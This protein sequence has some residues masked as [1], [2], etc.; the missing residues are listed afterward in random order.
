MI[1][2][3]I[4]NHGSAHP[5]GGKGIDKYGL[6]KFLQL[7]LS[8]L[9]MT[10]SV[11]PPAAR[12]LEGPV[13]RSEDSARFGE[14]AVLPSCMTLSVYRGD[15]TAGPSLLLIK[16]TDGCVVPWHWHTA[17]EELMM[18]SGTG[19]IEMKGMSPHSMAAGAYALLPAKNHHQFTCQSNCVMFDAIADTFDIHY[20]DATGNEIPVAQALQAVS[21]KPGGGP[22]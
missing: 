22:Q 18:V 15:P 5:I 1:L 14:L 7:A 20:L 3:R 21:E 2:I 16:A 17:R 13:V 12:G 8:V 19:R 6:S 10:F 4:E 9:F 11:S